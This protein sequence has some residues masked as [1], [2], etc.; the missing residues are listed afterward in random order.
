M[1]CSA[2]HRI[3]NMLISPP[4]YRRY[5]K[6]PKPD[7]T[8]PELRSSS[9]FYPYFK[10]VLGAIDCTHLDAFVPE[11]ALARYRD[12]KGR[13]SQNVL[14]ACT[15]DMRFSYVLP[16]WEGSAADGRVYEDARS[17]DFA[18][19]AGTSYLA[20]AGFPA[21]KSLLTPYRGVRYHLKEWKKSS[22]TYVNVHIHHTRLSLI[23]AAQRHQKSSTI[24]AMPLLA[25]WSSV[26]SGL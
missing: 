22:R 19:K 15:F 13:I 4:F 16:G 11:D 1:I 10:H 9:R 25:M 18:I 2:F 23:L 7:R 24:C 26:S 14:T 17:T 20:D 6:L 8:P 3:L 21:C 5:V 12:R